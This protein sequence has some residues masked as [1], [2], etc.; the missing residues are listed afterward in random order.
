VNR[1][2]HPEH[3]VDADLALALIASSFRGSGERIEA[4]GCEWDGGTTRRF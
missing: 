1:P 2:W 4:F 3:V